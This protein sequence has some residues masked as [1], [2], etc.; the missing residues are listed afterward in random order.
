MSVHIS[1]FK[2]PSLLLATIFILQFLTLAQSLYKACLHYLASNYIH[3]HTHTQMAAKLQRR[4]ALRRKL[5]ILRTL[6][7]SKSVININPLS[8]W[9]LL[10]YIYIY[11]LNSFFK[12]RL[13]FLTKSITMF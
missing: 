10:L 7:K 8:I 9:L 2:K 6:T 5:Q 11:V 13:W 4:M 12:L 3:T 1:T